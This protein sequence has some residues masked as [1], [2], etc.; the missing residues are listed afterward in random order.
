MG[1]T[2][3]EILEQ[4]EKICQSDA[5]EQSE[6]LKAFLRY[7]VQKSVHDPGVQPKEYAI[8]TEVFG[9]DPAFDPRQD[10]LVRVQAARLRSK[11]RKYYDT[12]GKS[13]RLL[14]DLPKGHY[15]PTFAYATGKNNSP[16][17]G[18]GDAT[19]DNHSPQASQAVEGQ[20]TIATLAGT[21]PQIQ[22]ARIAV[23]ALVILSLGL[24]Y[25]AFYYR[26]QLAALRDS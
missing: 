22:Y 21:A 9:R 10:A 23:A 20:R 4:V 2:Q 25:A 11:I 6:H 14:I 1:P 3:P 24:G 16:A 18:N 17:A 26:S 15:S 5:L 8:A 7:V 19:A 12:Q 13:D